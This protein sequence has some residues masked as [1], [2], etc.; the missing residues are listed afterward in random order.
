MV[1]NLYPYPC[2][3]PYP[4]LYLYPYPCLLTNLYPNHVHRHLPI[5]E[6]RI[7]KDLLLLLLLLL[8]LPLPPLTH[9]YPNHDLLVVQ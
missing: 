4:Y 9:L 5:N 6:Q 2:Y 3:Y 1:P 8:P 7:Y